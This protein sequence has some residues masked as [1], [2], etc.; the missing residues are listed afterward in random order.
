MKKL[1]I[2]IVLLQL[3]A[4]GA[5]LLGQN[6]ESQ[7]LIV[8]APTS[9]F[10]RTILPI[11]STEN[12][13]TSTNKWDEGWFNS[14]NVSTCTGCTS[15]VFAFPFTKLS[16]NEQSTSTTIV[17]G[18]G[19]IASAS[20]TLADFTFANATGTQ[21]TTTNFSSGVL[22]ITDIATST[23][24]GSI[25][26]QHPNALTVHAIRGDASDGARFLANNWAEVANFG[27]GNTTNS[28]FYGAV[29]IDGATRLATSLTGILKASS[30]SVSVATAGTDYLA[31]MTFA[32]PFTKLVSNE[33]A[34]STTL[35]FQNGFLSTASST[36]ISN[37]TFLAS[38]T[39]QAFTGTDYLALGSTTLQAFTGT[40]ASTTNLNISANHISFGSNY[41]G[42]TTASRVRIASTTAS[43]IAG[44]FLST[45]A[46]TTYTYV[47]F[48][49]NRTLVYY[50]CQTVGSVVGGALVM[51]GDG[52]NFTPFAFCDGNIRQ[53]VPASNNTWI[54]GEPI[55][56]KLQGASTTA[57]LVIFTESWAKTSD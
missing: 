11:D 27:V 49:E 39:L 57:D 34:T 56:Y 51:I 54:A 31:S 23:F 53:I 41:V 33:L 30:G 22:N 4:T 16:T 13:G 46:T 15:G 12:I 42:S 1:I 37:A 43:D 45:S 26:M 19:L 8:G 50:R 28:T 6:K 36:F 35:S 2:T 47:G 32:F 40:N 9:Q 55:V 5:W 21:A 48:P 10:S 38:T 25:Q 29:N 18:N 24:S 20:S 14:I 52:T 3:L 44:K 17:F 7:P